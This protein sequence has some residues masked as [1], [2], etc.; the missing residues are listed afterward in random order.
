MVSAR[1]KQNPRCSSSQNSTAYLSRN[2]LISAKSPSE[3]LV[4]LL[5]VLSFI[6]RFIII[7]S[8]APVF[9]CHV[10]TD[11]ANEETFGTFV[12]TAPFNSNPEVITLHLLKKK[13]TITTKTKFQEP[14]CPRHAKD[15]NRYDPF[16]FF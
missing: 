3:T 8:P 1:V 6:T 12:I 11:V 16:V 7:S 5:V 13:I 15:K 2:P 14:F 9:A 4:S 10:V